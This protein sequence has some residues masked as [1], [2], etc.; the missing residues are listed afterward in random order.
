MFGPDDGFGQLVRIVMRVFGSTRST[1]DQNESTQ[2]GSTE[3]KAGNRTARVSFGCG[4]V[5]TVN[6]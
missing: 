1:H 3:S 4:S 5:N 2:S 6:G